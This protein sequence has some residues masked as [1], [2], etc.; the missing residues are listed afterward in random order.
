MEKK[1]ACLNLSLNYQE[2]LN[3]WCDRG[4]L[5]ADDHQF[6]LSLSLSLVH[7]NYNP[8]SMGAI[9]EEERRR[10]EASVQRYNEKR[11]TRLF[12][13]KIRYQVR[14]LN[15]DNRP[16]FKGRF[17]KRSYPPKKIPK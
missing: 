9:L 6:S 10:R 15:A 5:W 4:P 13:K 7:P 16:R 11:Q 1:K 17:V 12:S 3:A 8:A 14:K 2:V